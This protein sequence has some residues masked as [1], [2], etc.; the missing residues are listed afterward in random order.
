MLSA[1]ASIAV[2]HWAVLLVP[3]FNFVLIGQLAASGQRRSAFAAVAGM[4]LGTLTWALL[5]VLGVGVVF[6]AHP[7]LRPRGRIPLVLARAALA[8]TRPA[9][10]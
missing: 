10:R 4:T 3:G 5:A 9:P 8:K 7:A 2:L 6:A 1:L